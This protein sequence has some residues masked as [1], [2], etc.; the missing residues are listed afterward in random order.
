MSV[1][2]TFVSVCEQR[3]AAERVLRLLQ[4]HS[5]TWTRVV[6]ILQKSQDINSKF[7]AL[8]VGHLL[9]GCLTV[10]LDGGHVKELVF[11]FDSIKPPICVILLRSPPPLVLVNR[12]WKVS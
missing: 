5:D 8:Q 10:S 2:E 12:F 11:K 3:A 7:Y 4:E 6:D 1:S 9:C